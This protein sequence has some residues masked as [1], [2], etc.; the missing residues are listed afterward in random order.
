MLTIL[1]GILVVVAIGAWILAVSAAVQIYRMMP[2]GHKLKSF[3][4]LGWLNFDHIHEIA[5]PAARKQTRRY[6]WGLVTF[7]VAIVLYA[8][9]IVLVVIESRN[10]AA[11]IDPPTASLS[12]PAMSGEA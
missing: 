7:F 10:A 1:I 2:A 9:V 11:D 4:N 6:V 8:A 3:F 5:G 12:V